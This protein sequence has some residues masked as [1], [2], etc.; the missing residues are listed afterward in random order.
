MG[1]L[2]FRRWD[3]VTTIRKCSITR[4]RRLI[5]FGQGAIGFGAQVGLVGWFRADM[6]Q[7]DRLPLYSPSPL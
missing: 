1:P 5:Q 3:S 6:G 7:T 4:G 2:F